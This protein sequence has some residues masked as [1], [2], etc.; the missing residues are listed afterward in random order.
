ML[1]CSEHGSCTL[2]RWKQG[3]RKGI[4]GHLPSL[5]RKRIHIRRVQG[6][7]RPGGQES[8]SR[9]PVMTL[10]WL[11][12]TGFSNPSGVPKAF[13]HPAPATRVPVCSFTFTPQTLSPLTSHLRHLAQDELHKAT[14]GTTGSPAPLLPL[15]RHPCLARGP[16][17][18]GTSP[19]QACPQGE[20]PSSSI[21]LPGPLS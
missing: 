12:R 11:M 3:P 10:A 5:T 19:S 6:S 13:T 21:L 1:T 16:L 2:P 9:T 14:K 20:S 18:K 15:E 4:H 7:E 17:Q 8:R